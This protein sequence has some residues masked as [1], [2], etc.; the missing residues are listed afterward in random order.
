[1]SWSHQALASQLL[2][3]QRIRWLDSVI[4]SM[5]ANLSKLW[6]TVENKGASC[7]AMRGVT[8]SWTRFSD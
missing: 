4:D 1:M 2:G 5:D 3:R 7:A 6:E 8:K